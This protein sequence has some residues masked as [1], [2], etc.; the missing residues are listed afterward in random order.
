MKQ[1]KVWSVSAAVRALRALAGKVGEEELGT[2]V[3]DFA[4]REG[5]GSRG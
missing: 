3:S 1:V 5:M 4:V 2:G